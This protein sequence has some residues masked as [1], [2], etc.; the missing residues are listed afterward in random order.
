MVSIIIATHN[1]TN[2]LIGLLDS[3]THQTFKNFDVVIVND[4]PKKLRIKK[5]KF[6]V[7]IIENGNRDLWW[8][9]SINVGLRHTLDSNSSFILILNDDVIIENNY[10]QE[11]INFNKEKHNIIQGP[12][13]FDF[14]KK[15]K[16]WAAGGRI[17]WPFKGAYHNL[18][19]D[20]S[21]EIT[22]VDWLP[23]MGTFFNKNI[24]HKTGLLKSK[25]HPQ[26]LSDTDFTLS[27]K[28]LG[29]S[30]CVNHSLILYNE[31][32]STGG[33]SKQKMSL[34][35]IKTVFFHKSSPEYIY[36]RIPFIKDHSN[37][38]FEFIITFLFHYLKL[39]MFILKKLLF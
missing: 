35:D 24:L 39:S 8:A 23:G 4:Y 16:L 11:A 19:V 1:R 30:I 22:D 29:F 9:E 13:I 5:Y 15:N 27:A 7:N 6:N 31:T 36:S 26:Y 32:L 12:L 2:K 10:L 37:H 3:L 21:T 25:T 17:S 34:G 28:R 18:I 33:I 14:N 20:N 38:T